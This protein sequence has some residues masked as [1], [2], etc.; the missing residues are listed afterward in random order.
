VASDRTEDTGPGATGFD[1]PRYPRILV[2][3]DETPAAAFALRHVVPYAVEQ[4]SQLTLL[5][6]V[7]HPPRSAAAAGISLQQL[8]DQMEREAATHLREVAAT[9]PQ[10]LSVT[11]VLRHGDPAEEILALLAEQPFDMLCMGARGRGRVTGAVLGSVS[12]AV[13][14]HSP[15]P[16]MVLHPPRLTTPTE[17]GRMT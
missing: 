17:S 2:A 12:T 9:L 16:V 10:E 6:V 4:R 1:W 14:H 15:V 8:A 11:T 13:L 5:S 7:P 3:I